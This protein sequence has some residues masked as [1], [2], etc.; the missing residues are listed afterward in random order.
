M[1]KGEGLRALEERMK[2]LTQTKTKCTSF[3]DASKVTKSMCKGYGEGRKESQETEE[4]TD[5]DE[6]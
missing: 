2:V 6:S 4:T 1:V 3:S 5:E